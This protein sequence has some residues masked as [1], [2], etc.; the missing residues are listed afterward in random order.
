MMYE[1]FSGGNAPLNINIL[2]T[3]ND[4]KICRYGPTVR[5]FYIAHY[6]ISGKGY[7]NG[8]PVNAGQGFLIYPGQHEIYYP[9]DNNPWELVW[10]V[11]ADAGMKD[12]FESFNADPNSLIFNFYSPAVLKNVRDK[13]IALNNSITDSMQILEL[14]LHI[15]NNCTDRDFSYK[16]D[17]DGYI[18][19]CCD[20]IEMHI[21]EKITVDKLAKLTGISRPYL[22]KIFR[23]RF[24]MSVKEY[25][26]KKKTESAKAL[27]IK[28]DL[29]IF[30]I[31]EA[32]GYGDA[33]AFSKIF[34]S[35]EKL[36]PTAY[37]SM[38]QK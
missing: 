15:Y 8:N 19:F 11:S 14:F 13:I 18:D 7:Y 5:N 22:Y 38:Y 2:G 12:V 26:L 35:Y 29:P 3:S 32:V 4:A 20:Y 6:C 17:I 16:N 21:G 23:E 10:V 1:L 24:G 31:S 27:L 33:L 36:S 9:D 25:V 28:T 37:R 34:K 30:K